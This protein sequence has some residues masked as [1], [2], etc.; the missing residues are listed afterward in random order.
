MNDK[1]DFE[2]VLEKWLNCPP[3]ISISVTFDHIQG[4]P[5]TVIGFMESTEDYP[6]NTNQDLV[7]TLQQ[8]YK[9]KYPDC[10]NVR[11]SILPKPSQ[12]CDKE[13]TK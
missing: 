9:T 1:E 2:G 8:K 10:T 12:S 3:D 4:K 6:N 11:I 13:N 7:E 5:Y